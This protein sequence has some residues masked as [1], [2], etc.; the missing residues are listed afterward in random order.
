MSHI[1]N[2]IYVSDVHMGDFSKHLL[3]NE[4]ATRL[5]SEGKDPS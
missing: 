5:L 3:V 4:A 1:K 2:Y